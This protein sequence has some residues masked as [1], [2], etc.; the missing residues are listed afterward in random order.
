M[1]PGAEAAAARGLDW[2][3]RHRNADDGWGDAPGAPSN[4][5][6]T[7]LVLACFLRLRPGSPAVEWARRW[8]GRNGGGW[9]GPDLP[10]TLLRT[11]GADRTFSFPILA[12]AAA[13]G[14][15]GP[16]ETAWVSVPHLPCELGCLPHRALAALRI[17]VVSY[18]LPALIAMGLDRHRNAP[19]PG[20]RHR[21]RDVL[22]PRLL[23]RLA[24]LQPS[25]GGYL[26][27]VPLTAFV[28]VALSAAGLE[29]HPIVDRAH[30]FL[31]S[32]QRSDGSWP[33]DRDL[34]VWLTS[35]AV[36]ALCQ[37]D[38]AGRLWPAAD[39]GRVLGWLLG[40]QWRIPH[41]FTGAAPG[42]W[43]WTDANGGCRTPT[44]PPRPY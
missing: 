6:A 24:A 37:A 25:S 1:R 5:T 2:I 32:L 10:A 12:F 30:R 8:L 42:G 41:P 26:E 36:T 34:R 19:T 39:R 18:A 44:T 13:C 15:L 17:P 14:A 11:Y 31:L 29:E 4:P 35:Q 43:G 7:F 21:L 27:A 38:P 33:I 20:L 9:E 3:E 22:T 28:A 23:L 16:R 40:R